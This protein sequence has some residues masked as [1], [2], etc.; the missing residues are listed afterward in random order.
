MHK[1]N[2]ALNGEWAQHVRPFLKKKTAK[3]R[4]RQGQE[5]VAAGVAGRERREL[6]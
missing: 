6:P 1:A 5:S 4:R 2:M 3:A